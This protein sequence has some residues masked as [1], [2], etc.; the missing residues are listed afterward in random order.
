MSF[1]AQVTEIAAVATSQSWTDESN[2]TFKV[3]VTMDPLEIDLRAG[4]TAKVEIQ[5][6]RLEDQLQ[7]PIHAVF[8]ENGEHFVYVFEDGEL[9]RRVVEVAKNNVHHVAI[10]DGLEEGERV[11]LYDPRDTGEAAG[12]EGAPGV[13]AGDSGEGEGLGAG[14]AGMGGA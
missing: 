5:V 12:G 14:L 6:E 8:P 7:V 11:L 4:V 2:K 3:E 1:G 13:E 9:E 10:A